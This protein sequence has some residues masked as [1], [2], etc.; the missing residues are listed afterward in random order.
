MSGIK[1]KKKRI[2]LD[3]FSR[4]TVPATLGGAVETLY[5]ILMEQNEIYN[6][7]DLYIVCSYN[8]EAKKK[9]KKYRNTKVIYVRKNDFE[10]RIYNKIV[11]I[12]NSFLK[13]KKELLQYDFAKENKALLKTKADI[14]VT[15][16]CGANYY[17][18]EKKVGRDNMYYYLHCEA[19]AN[20]DSD[21]IF[22]HTISVSDY[23]KRS[24][25][26]TSGCSS[27][28]GI[29][30]R[31]CTREEIFSKR[32][33]ADEKAELRKKL[34]FEEDDFVV[35]YTGRLAENKGPHVLIDALEKVEI[36]KVK[37]LI[38]GAVNSGLQTKDNY[39]TFFTDKVNKNVDRVR[40]TGYIDH[41]ELYKY[42]Q[43]ADIQVVPSLWEEP[44]G[45]VAIE[46][47]YSGL[48][49]IVTESGGMVEYIS[50]DCAIVVKKDD[51]LATAIA[52][53]IVKLKE[54]SDLR[55][56]MREE[57]IKKASLYTRREYYRQFAKIFSN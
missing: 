53:N 41:N 52:E 29:V 56:R 3:V 8:K 14:Y 51:N 17:P 33:S 42:Y 57:G 49:L 24:Y 26:K 43:V 35:L 9:S 50:S 13:P 46:G 37:L 4:L 30:I 1:Y 45:L 16:G 48:P 39:L 44:A 15:N 38:C 20:E 19:N 34:G 10:K 25:Y 36:K 40:Y 11:K 12:L 28:D 6:E 2:C 32:I 18:V 7:L 31:N 5:E 27:E 21:R 55:E 22:G 23:I 47:M 54:N